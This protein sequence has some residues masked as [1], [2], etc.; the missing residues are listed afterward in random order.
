MG[1]IPMELTVSEYRKVGLFLLPHI[2]NQQVGPQKIASKVKEI[3]YD[4][5][6]EESQLEPPA[7]IKTLIATD[8]K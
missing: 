2:S 6:I 4:T 3:L 5:T 1:E 8:K 7:E